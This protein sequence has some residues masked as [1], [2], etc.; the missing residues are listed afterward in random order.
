MPLLWL[1][2]VL[3]GAGFIGAAARYMAGESA[4][5]AKDTFNYMAV[6]TKDGVKTVTTAMGEGLATGAGIIKPVQV[7]CVKCN[8]SNN[9]D[10]KFCK[11]CGATLPQA[12]ACPACQATNDANA[13]FCDQCGRTIV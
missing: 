3:C 2:G 6:E 10:S 7:P 12:K 9:A 13:K 4:P 1:G 5:V 8:E 11:S